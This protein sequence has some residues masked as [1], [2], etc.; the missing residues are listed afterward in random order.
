M[1]E[2]LRELNLV[3]YDCGDSDFNKEDL[4]VLGIQFGLIRLDKNVMADSASISSVCVADGN[5]GARY[6]PYTNRPL[7]WHTDG[8]YNDAIRTIRSFILHCV[9]PAPDGGT[10]TF[11]DPDIVYFLVEHHS[12]EFAASLARTDAFSV[13][14]NTGD[15]GELRPAFTGPVFSVVIVS[16]PS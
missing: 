3:V 2:H 6:I 12:A 16:G 14:A 9:R 1:L 5:T 8:Y 10:N 13:P 4:K 11:L 15:N 7:G